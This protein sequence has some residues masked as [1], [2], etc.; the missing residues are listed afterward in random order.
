[1][2]DMLIEGSQSTRLAL[3]FEINKDVTLRSFI[4]A[5]CFKRLVRA[6][7][8]YLGQS[9]GDDYETCI[10]LLDKIY[11]TEL[12][13]QTIIKL[14]CRQIENTKPLRFCSPT[15]SSHDHDS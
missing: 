1:M 11:E 4:G 3:D 2:L 5:D 15:D 13:L 12:V 7:V 14:Q 8:D 10:C 6:T 9:G